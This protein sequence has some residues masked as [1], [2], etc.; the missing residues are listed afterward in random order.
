MKQ[1]IDNFRQDWATLLMVTLLLLIP[2]AAL[3]V[4]NWADGLQVLSLIVLAAVLMSYLLAISRFSDTMILIMSIVYGTLAVWSVMA[5]IL[6]DA[7]T[8]RE[9]MLEIAF[10]AA[11]WIERALG[12]GISR[13]NLM[14]VLLMAG[15]FWFLSFNAV[16][17]VF[18]SQRLWM[19]VVPP[20]L[21]LLINTYYYIGKTR[22]D[23][24]LIAY[25]FLTLI[26]VVRT[27]IQLREQLWTSMRVGYTPGIHFDLLRGGLI[28][29]VL[30]LFLAWSL[31][32]ASASNRLASAWDRS[33][34]PW[35]RFQDTFSRLFNGLQGQGSASADYY[36]GATLSMG[37]PTNLG[38]QTVM[39][40]YAPPGHHYYWR[41][42]LFD[43]YENGRWT[44]SSEDRVE[45]DFG[46]II[47]ETQG[48][49]ALRTNV[50][51]RFQI[52]I[53][54]TRLVYAAPQPT[55]FSSLPVV[56]DV[57]YNTP[58]QGQ[59]TA[60]AVRAANLLMS[61]RKYEA[62]SS[63]SIADETSLRA[64]NTDYPAWVSERY[65]QLPDT[66]T[67]RT[68]DLA[69]AVTA[70]FDNPYDKA[71]AVEAY[72]RDHIT[73]N[74]QVSAPP[75]NVEPVDYVLFD[76]TEGY[77][78]YYASAMTIMLRAVGIPARVA[79]GFA[80][81]EFDDSLNAFRVL[82]A[83]AHTWVE[84]FFPGFGWVE[85]EPTSAIQVITRPEAYPDAFL[86]EQPAPGELPIGAGGITP[87]AE[88]PFPEEDLIDQAEQAVDLSAARPIPTTLAVLGGV[89]ALALLLGLVV[90]VLWFRFEQW[91]L[92]QLSEVS[93]SYARLN[94][95]AQLL[96][97]SASETATPY[98]H[99]A[100]LVKALPEGRSPI[101]A[102]VNL[103][104]IEQYGPPPSM[105]VQS[106][107]RNAEAREAWMTA[108][109]I[110]LKRV[111]ERIN[112]FSPQ[113]Y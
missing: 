59:G 79:A 83:D 1:L 57:I 90:F 98:E 44:A 35:T 74:R 12:G 56:Y 47:P 113:T 30:L 21:A 73:Y 66:I 18:R 76:R 16:V 19:A 112:I 4:P 71:R 82:E 49:Y 97:I 105:P 45:S 29:I 61:G 23:F 43:R 101:S 55:T 75:S 34:N 27:N 25:L 104:V 68:R 110:I 70:Q 109:R 91:G 77:C 78:N 69:I 3:A 53:P 39:Y 46:V 20:G 86:E 67:S 103:Y 37:G 65:L 36:G 14:F 48:F 33:I 5:L 100:Q 111:L 58:G 52:V 80:Q 81:G 102:I 92:M 54:A 40:V 7:F 10:R 72:L 50:Q 94:T 84:A 6:P 99:A 17:N 88:P 42:K 85:F 8:F 32:A 26:L 106:A 108:R 64:A 87:Q 60:T 51:Q 11:G 2:A 62:T 38:N 22:M 89:F 96:D 24:F 63:I 107:R 9:R 28:I 31:P 13:D 93:R 41:S 15:C 95:Y